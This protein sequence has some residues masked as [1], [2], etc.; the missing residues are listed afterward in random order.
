[1]L[2][3]F[4]LEL[5]AETRMRLGVFTTGGACCWGY[6]GESGREE[7]RTGERRWEQ[8]QER[9]EDEEEEGDRETDDTHTQRERRE[10]RGERHN[11]M[12]RKADKPT[13]NRET[14]VTG[15]SRAAKSRCQKC[16]WDGPTETLI[17]I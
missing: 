17:C 1:L 16:H 7:S 5:G 10:T 14:R 9:R 4:A 8:G 15:G 6:S 12:E 13:G 2:F 11:R 3:L